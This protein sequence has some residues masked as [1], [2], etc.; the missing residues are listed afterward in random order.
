M[1]KKF[2]YITGEEITVDNL[3]EG[4]WIKTQKGAERL[5]HDTI[6]RRCDECGFPAMGIIHRDFKNQ[7]LRLGCP[8]CSAFRE[9]CLVCGHM[10]YLLKDHNH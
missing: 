1:G 9:L 5:L 6:P 4:K 3:E 7:T 10:E 2:Q 8:W